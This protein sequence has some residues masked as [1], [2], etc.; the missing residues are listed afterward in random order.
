MSLQQLVFVF[1]YHPSETCLLCK[2][3]HINCTMCA[4][5]CC[6]RKSKFSMV[7]VDGANL[8]RYL[9]RQE[10]VVDSPELFVKCF[11]VGFKSCAV[12]CSLHSSISI[13]VASTSAQEVTCTLPCSLLMHL[14]N[15][16]HVFMPCPSVP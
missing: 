5:L 4:L 1:V 15:H 6:H 2:K 7:L 3:T 9:V 12:F 8:T 10:Q 14:I 16:L 11:K 13:P